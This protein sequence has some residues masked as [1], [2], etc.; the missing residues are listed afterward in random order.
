MKKFFLAAGHWVIA[1][2]RDGV[3]QRHRTCW[4]SNGGG[5]DTF[6]NTEVATPAGFPALYTSYLNQCAN[7]HAPGAPGATSTTEQTLDFSSGEHGRGE[8]EGPGLG[9]DGQPQ[10]CNGGG[11]PGRDVRGEPA[12]QRVLDQSVRSAIAITSN[13]KCNRGHESRT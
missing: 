10:D 2:R 11:V 4:D 6:T 9:P 5:N 7:C 3:Q 8:P 12:G 13:P 1:V